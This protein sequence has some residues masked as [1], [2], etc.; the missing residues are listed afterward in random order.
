ML[1]GR[2]NLIRDFKALADR[3]ALGQGYIFFGP[4]GVGKRSFAESLAFY[5]ERQEFT[6]PEAAV[7]QDAM[8]I[9]PKEGTLGIDV[10]REIRRFLWQKPNLSKYRTVILD[11]AEYLTDE[12]QNALLKI[13]EEPPASGLLLLII[14]DP[15]KLRPTLQSR[16]PKIYVAPVT[17]A[18]LAEW[19]KKEKKLPAEKAKLLAEAALGA[20]GV[21]LAFLNDESFEKR[22]TTARKFLSTS[23]AGR[24]AFVKELLTDEEFSLYEFMGTVLFAEGKEWRECPAA[25]HAACELRRQ[26][27]YFNLNA[28]LQLLALGQVLDARRA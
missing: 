13:T 12:A 7:L 16:L 14:D 8:R 15:E 1:L 17:I 6:L 27:S 2:E 24:S 20:P 4:A 19:L 9:A 28:R 22:L 25:W 5:L 26:A 23:A 18:A 3:Q 21:A 10:I 11:G